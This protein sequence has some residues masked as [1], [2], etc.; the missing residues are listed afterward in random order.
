MRVA[1]LGLGL[2][3]GSIAR[4]LRA[5]GPGD[6]TIA[7]WTPTGHGPAAALADGVIDDAA[8]TPEAAVAG[9][10]LVVL[11]GPVPDCLAM[12]DELAGPW[13]TALD[14]DAVITDVASTKADLVLR[15]TALGVRFVGGHPMAGRESSG[16]EAASADL[17]VDRPWVIIPSADATAAARVEDLAR[18]VGARPIR[19]TAADHDAA[20]AGISHLPL[21]V[22]AA[23][24]EAVAGGAGEPRP[25]WGAAADLAA[26]GW[27][28][29]TRLARGDVTMGT[30]IAVTNGPA[31]A[32][33]VRDL[34]AVLD[35]WAA[36]LETPGGVDRTEV[37]ER[38]TAARERLEAMGT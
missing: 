18:A 12:L 10:G 36:L 3:G 11:A 9:A 27:R 6:W 24:V 13:G 21:V 22:A 8:A 14:P 20:V 28:D 1:L 30:G 4:A 7:A 15:A 2:I 33:R 31:I 16:Y 37:T 25:G 23:L 32:A 5:R 29:T 34:V 19:M 26:S 38:L 35:A 17:F